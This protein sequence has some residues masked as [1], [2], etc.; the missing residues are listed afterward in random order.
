MHQHSSRGGLAILQTLYRLYT[1]YW[2]LSPSVS[3][4]LPRFPSRSPSPFISLHLPCS[5]L[6]SPFFPLLKRLKYSS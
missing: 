2:P 5:Y 4:F 3:S 6:P 1:F